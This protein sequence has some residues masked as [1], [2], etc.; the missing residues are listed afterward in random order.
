MKCMYVYMFVHPETELSSKSSYCFMYSDA[1]RWENL[2]WQKVGDK[3]MESS[4]IF[5]IHECILMDTVSLSLSFLNIYICN[6]D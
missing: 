4:V 5:D 1:D 6:K 3:P 2:H